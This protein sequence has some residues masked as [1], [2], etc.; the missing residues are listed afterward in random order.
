MIKIIINKL[1]FDNWEQKILSEIV[2][3]KKRMRGSIL[4]SFD[5]MFDLLNQLLDV[6]TMFFSQNKQL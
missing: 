5:I 6:F 3:K 2:S 4:I 1:Y